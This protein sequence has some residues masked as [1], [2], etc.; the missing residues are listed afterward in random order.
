MTDGIRYLT[1]TELNEYV[2]LLLDSDPLLGGVW[3]RAEISNFKHHYATGHM[4]FSLKDAGGLV[5]AVMFRFQAQRLA[6]EPQDGMKVLVH[7]KVSSFIRDGQYQLYVDE[8]LPDGKGAL[9]VAFEQLK[10][11]LEAQGLFDAARKRPLPRFPESI[12]IITSPTG[13]AIRD[14]IHILKRRYPC[15]LLYLYP[16]Q[17]QGPEAPTQLVRGL[18][19]FNRKR[20]TDVIIIGRGGG[21]VE[22]LWAFNNEELAYS[23][24]T[25]AIPVISAVGHES[26]FTICDFV[27]DLRAPTPSAAAELA[28]PDRPELK[29]NL[30]AY[31]S[32][33]L[34][35]LGTRVENARR[36][37]RYIGESGILSS[38]EK[39]T[40]G[41]RMSLVY[42]AE[43][44][45]AAMGGLMT[46][47]KAALGRLSA[48]MQALSPLSVLARGYAIATNAEGQTISSVDDV[49]SGDEVA[50]KVSDGS[51]RMTVCE[52]IKEGKKSHGKNS[53]KL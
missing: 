5:R 18:K 26:D 22:D 36:N 32:K 43:K 9:Y 1:V 30:K 33:M 8:M 40:E 15:V 42:L 48:Q 12:G 34:S 31:E 50:L 16:A 29:K 3:V 17:V 45:D 27:A 52:S 14:M 46:E 38:P 2:K 25:S 37:L 6:F 24:A 10:A 35:V 44:A 4:Y 51:I 19:F 23:V 7:G 49:K 21:S 41:R 39:M 53:K 11:K 47:K 20:P 28:V 13:A